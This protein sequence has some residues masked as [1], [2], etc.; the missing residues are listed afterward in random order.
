MDK[1]ETPV[2]LSGAKR[3]VLSAVEG[4][5]P[6]QITGSHGRTKDGV[7]ARLADVA[8]GSPAAAAGLVSG[9]Y[10]HAVDSQ[11]LRDIIDWRWN[12]ADDCITVTVSDTSD[13]SGDDV[14][15]SREPGTDWGIAFDDIIFDHIHT[16]VN[17]CSFCFMKQ[18]P[19]GMRADLALRDDDWR[20]SF[21]QGNFVTLTN[22]RDADI[23]RI[24]EQHVSP[25]NL[26]FH[27]IDP[28]LRTT[29]MGTHQ[30]RALD[31]FQQLA[32]GGIRFNIQIVLIPGVNDGAQLDATLDWLTAPERIDAIHSIGIVPVAWTDIGAARGMAPADGRGFTDTMASATVISQIQRRQFE[33]KQRI[34]RNIIHLADEF[35]IAANAPFPTEE[36]YDGYPQREN[37]IGLVHAFV[38][39]VREH[40]SQLSDA[41]ASLPTGYERVTIVTGELARDSWLGALS[42][43]NAGGRLRLLPVRNRHFGGNVT[44]TGLLTARD[45]LDACAYDC[46]LRPQD[47]DGLLRDTYLYP[48]QIFNAD[49]VTLDDRTAQQLT[50]DA[51]KRSPAFDLYSW[52]E[53]M[54]GLAETLAAVARGYATQ[55]VDD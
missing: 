10:V 21:L 26:S 54:A 43:L 50:A 38:A 31:A 19:D 53:G 32:D 16:C 40:F 41:I 30:A 13:G 2:I 3:V 27:A 5:T 14:V 39:D 55:G 20:L 34:G 33:L 44:V 24:I 1:E 8:P 23:A 49:G 36:W 6:E 7:S 47:A 51:L 12:A 18:L 9:M 22:M 29:L 48:D 17:D 42:A 11:P 35:Y 25:L 15:L 4:S 37:G 46:S 45:I 28:D 52:S